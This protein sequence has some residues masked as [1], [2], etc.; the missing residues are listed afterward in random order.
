MASSALTS[1]TQEDINTCAFAHPPLR[2]KDIR[3][4]GAEKKEEKIRRP[5]PKKAIELW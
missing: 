2:R 5:P 3:Q 4:G 1:N